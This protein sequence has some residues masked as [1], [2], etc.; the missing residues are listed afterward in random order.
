VY[1]KDLSI[2]LGNRQLSDIIIVDNK[3]ESY[4]SNLE[5]GIPIISYYGQEGDMMLK[6]L[7]I[8]LKKNI[9]D[10]ED[11]RQCISR[12]FYVKDL[13]SMQKFKR[14]RIFDTKEIKAIVLKARD[15]QSILNSLRNQLRPRK[16]CGMEDLPNG[17]EDEE[18]KEDDEALNLLTP[19]NY[20]SRRA[21]S[22]HRE[23]PVPHHG[24]QSP[25]WQ[26]FVDNRNGVDGSP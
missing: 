5:N 17:D 3:V 7:A 14:S 24:P 22:N 19:I 25:Q 10:A 8:Y 26:L 12:D 4:S 11:V 21:D 2:L 9:K 16:T 6:K 13:T 1:I 23:K 20:D 15:Q 18:D